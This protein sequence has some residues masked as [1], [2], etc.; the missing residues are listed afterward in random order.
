MVGGGGAHILIGVF[1][2]GLV[3]FVLD[4]SCCAFRLP[5]CRI[6][7][8]LKDVAWLTVREI[9]HNPSSLW[10]KFMK[11]SIKEKPIPDKYPIY[12]QKTKR[13]AWNWQGNFLK[14]TSCRIRGFQMYHLAMWLGCIISSPRETF[15]NVLGHE[16]PT[17]VKRCRT[18]KKVLYNIWTRPSN[19]CF[20]GQICNCSMLW[21][22]YTSRIW[23]CYHRLKF[24]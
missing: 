18:V 13:S 3:V 19:S 8:I 6:R 9:A 23:K 1:V 11:F 22:C 21:K 17:T 4:D 2:G 15:Q 5:F 12:C 10:Q 24:I 14:C 16:R 7:H 20:L